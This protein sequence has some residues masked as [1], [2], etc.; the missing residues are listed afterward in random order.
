MDGSDDDG[1]GQLSDWSIDASRFLAQ[2]QSR[3]SNFGRPDQG[4]GNPEHSRFV[5]DRSRRPMSTRNSRAFFQRTPLGNPYLSTTAPLF[6]SATD[7]AREDDEEREREASDRLAL[8]ASRR[9]FSTQQLQESSEAGS[10]EHSTSTD[11][12]QEGDGRVRE[13]RGFASRT[14]NSSW[15][16][17]R[18]ADRGKRKPADAL[19]EEDDEPG[20]GSVRPSTRSM[21]AGSARMEDIGLESTN[22]GGSPEELAL[23]GSPDDR[24][25]AFQGFRRPTGSRSEAAKPFLQFE[26]QLPTEANNVHAYESDA[27]SAAPPLAQSMREI[28][29]HDSFWGT[30]YLV[31]MAAIFATYILVWLHTEQPAKK[32]PLGDTIYSVINSSRHLLAVDTLVAIIVSLLWLAALRSFVRPLVFSILVGVPIILF[33]FTLYPFISS[34]KGSWKGHSAQDSAMR[35]SSLLPAIATVLWVYTSWKARHALGKAIAILEFSS[36]V[37]AA[38]PALVVL[39]FGTLFGVVAWTWI[40]MGMFTRVFLGGHF[41]KNT[42]IIDLGS[43]WLGAWFILMYLWTL[44][45][46][47][48]IQRATTA[49]TVSQWYFHRNAVPS[50]ASTQVVQAAFSHSTSSL[51][52]TIALSTLLSLLIRLPLLLL[53]RR[54]TALTG[55]AF[56]SF[57][58]TSILTITNPLTLTYAAVHS[59]PLIASSRALTSMSFLAISSPTTTLSPRAAASEGAHAAPLLPYRLAKLLLHA[60]R[61]VMALALGFAGWVS[62][63]RMLSVQGAAAGVRGS[64]YAYIVGLIAGAIG[65]AV[66]GSMEGVLGGVT[67]A[68]VVCWGSEGRHGA[69]GGYCLEA[70]WLFSDEERG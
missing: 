25:P 39:G 2:S 33:S 32:R 51:F 54:L 62:T 59:Q 1:H 38:N 46:G 10:E 41:S 44:S 23:G 60:T 31:S 27:E 21:S 53:P 28:P 57:I 16:G 42:F 43:W 68:L 3:L 36:K 67:D 35:W 66:L 14:I 49:A 61:F 18:G 40:W 20:E 19:L 5:Q 13:S 37:L 70:R 56:Y 22:L 17:E 11:N 6:Y 4:N 8:Q 47:S 64:L 29:K 24:P 55:V 63:A 12:S 30:L 9:Y 45:L 65:W 15:R 52:G 50:P 26:D 34:F 69:M 7:D 58:P 48:G